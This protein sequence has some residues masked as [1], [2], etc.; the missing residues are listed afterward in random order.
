[1]KQKLLFITLAIFITLPA[2]GQVII[3]EE[4][5]ETNGA[6]SRYTVSSEFY[7]TVDD[8]FGR[9]HGPSLEYSFNGSGQ[10]IE[11]SGTDIVAQNGNYTNY[12]GSYYM[13]GEDQDDAGGT[14]ADGVDEKTVTFTVDISNDDTFTFKGLFG[15]G[16]EGGCDPTNGYDST[17]Y[18]EVSYNVDGAGDVLALRFSADIDCNMPGDN[19]NHDLYFDPD[20]DGDGGEGTLMSGAMQEF[21]FPFPDGNSVV[22]TVVTH[23]DAG[24]EEMAYDY[25]RIEAENTLGITESDYL[26]SITVS[27]NPSNG[28]ITLT[29]PAGLDLQQAVVYN[30]IGKQV[31]SINLVTMT[32]TK[33]IDLSAL[34]SGLYLVNIQ[35]SNGNAIT[36]KLIIK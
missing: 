31:K 29:K 23:A 26:N 11:L 30:V 28:M 21:S 13:A 22:I 33:A 2:L 20:M 7:D 25:L 4:D 3:W 18:I 9:I 1:M 35:T 12:N 8:Y 32:D 5:F 36:K 16:N 19:S 27:P 17:D 34:A 6:G 15:A 10:D 14:G 24:E